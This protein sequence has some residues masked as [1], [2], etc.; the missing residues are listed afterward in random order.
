MAHGVL[1]STTAPRELLYTG[2]PVEVIVQISKG[3]QQSSF[4]FV[5]EIIRL[6]LLML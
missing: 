4:F 3:S 6:I 5:F 1:G 2:L